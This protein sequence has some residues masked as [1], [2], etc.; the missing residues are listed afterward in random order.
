[1]RWRGDSIP[2]DSVAI[3]ERT[4]VGDCLGPD[5]KDENRYIPQECDKA[6]ATV[7]IIGTEARL[8]SASP[9][10][11]PGTDALVDAKQGIVLEGEIV[12]PPETWCLRNLQPPHPGDLGMGGGQLLPEECFSLSSAGE[13]IEIP[14]A[15]A[16]EGGTQYRLLDIVRFSSEC[17]PGTTEELELT[18]VPPEVLCGATL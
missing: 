7:E 12:G 3:D 11:P 15:E 16:G 17:P 8:L 18:T 5:P 9:K 14:C 6:D 10:C 13:I 2:R 4:E 1:M